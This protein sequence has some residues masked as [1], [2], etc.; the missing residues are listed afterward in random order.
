MSDNSDIEQQ[1]QNEQNR[2]N[3]SLANIANLQSQTIED[4]EKELQIQLHRNDYEHLNNQLNLVETDL[5]NA[6][7]RYQK[8]LDPDFFKKREEEF[9]RN[10]LKKL[11]LQREKVL[12]RLKNEYGMRTRCNNV[13]YKL[14][15]TN[16]E[17]INTQN[18]TIKNIRT[19][20]DNMKNDKVYKHRLVEINNYNVKNIDRR[21]NIA[22]TILGVIVVGL[23]PT[24]LSFFNL[25]SP[26]LALVSIIV[27]SIIGGI[28]IY[29]KFNIT[30]NRSKRIW[31]LRNFTEPKNKSTSTNVDDT[32]TPEPDRELYVEDGQTLD[33]VL[34]AKLQEYNKCAP[35]IVPTT[36]SACTPA[37][38]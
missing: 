20:I 27:F 33:D 12:A 7:D 14:N 37:T 31:E 34:S 24:L 6:Y 15:K 9:I 32:A 22:I 26:L 2:A 1:L 16:N 4:L 10:K 13:T 3:E 17:Y 25:I 11:R 18:K 8:S 23:I 38:T 35:V 5:K 19:N 29:F 21:I 30:P 28:I 36:P